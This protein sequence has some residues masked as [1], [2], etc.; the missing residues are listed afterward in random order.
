MLDAITKVITAEFPPISFY[1]LAKPIL[2]SL[3]RS[4]I[5]FLLVFK[6]IINSSF[7]RMGSVVSAIPS[8]LSFGQEADESLEN[9]EETCVA[10]L[11]THSPTAQ[12]MLGHSL[13]HSFDEERRESQRYH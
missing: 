5:H 3:L 1:H 8:R 10:S 6:S 4:C 12:E 7:F 11:G 9:P 2:G 13:L